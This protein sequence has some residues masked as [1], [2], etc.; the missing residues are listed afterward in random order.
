M[1]LKHEA[2]RA[3]PEGR[4]A[5]AELACCCVA[6]VVP[7]GSPCT[8]RADQTEIPG[9]AAGGGLRG[10]DDALLRAGGPGT[11]AIR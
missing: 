9:P 2:V 6:A 4:V 10:H 1:R 7:L 5:L 11:A 8:H 3:R